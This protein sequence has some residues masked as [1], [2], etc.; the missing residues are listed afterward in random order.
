MLLILNKD[1]EEV[2]KELELLGILRN[3]I[4]TLNNGAQQQYLTYDRWNICAVNNNQD[5][6]PI[7]QNK[8]DIYDLRFQLFF[9]FNYFVIIMVT[10]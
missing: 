8:I 2:Q 1:R 7:M 4:T 3:N 10:I 5:F 6:K 9:F